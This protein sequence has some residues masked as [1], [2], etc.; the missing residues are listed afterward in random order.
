MQVHT[1]FKVRETLNL[2]HR[3]VMMFV[4]IVLVGGAILAWWYS[5][6]GNGLLLV[7][8]IL[9][10]L[11]LM[12]GLSIFRN[13]V[14]DE[15]EAETLRQMIDV[16]R[17]VAPSEKVAAIQRL[18]QGR[19]VT[20]SVGHSEPEV[21]R[22]DTE[23]LEDA[24]RMAAQGAPLDDICSAVDHEFHSRDPLHKD[25]FRRIVQAMIDQG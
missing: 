17:D 8:G 6:P 18:M 13:E 24:K 7:A 4:T 5:T 1:L 9:G 19:P 20:V 25:A 12:A 10:L 15:A 2:I 14:I 21:H 16:A 11:A 3:T 23:T 22:V